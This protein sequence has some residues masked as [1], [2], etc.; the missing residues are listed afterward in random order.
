MDMGREIGSSR[1][2]S[3]SS[4]PVGPLVDQSPYDAAESAAH[5]SMM[6]GARVPEGVVI[7]SDS[8]TTTS[9]FST[10]RDD[11]TKV[12]DFP[13]AGILLGC[14]NNDELADQLFRR[15]STWKSQPPVEQITGEVTSA[16]LKQARLPG[17]TVPSIQVL[18]GLNLVGGSGLVRYWESDG[19][20]PIEE[21]LC[22]TS[23]PGEHAAYLLRRY[24]N[25]TM[26]LDS[27]IRLLIAV[28]VETAEFNASVGGPIQVGV[29]DAVGPRLLDRAEIDRA[30]VE[31]LDATSGI[32]ARVRRFLGA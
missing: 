5:M 30:A 17:A 3:D 12:L 6:I 28:L 14:V 25:P 21:S 32:P 26:C 29:L 24:G 1:L 15:A 8:R 18:A 23:P 22:W 27:V 31:W 2:F 9:S 4:S 19:W 16:R 13:D 11:R 10:F 20:T 7:A